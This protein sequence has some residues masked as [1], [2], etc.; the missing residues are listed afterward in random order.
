M[1][2]NPQNVK[3]AKDLLTALRNCS[4]RAELARA[5]GVNPRTVF[6]WQSKAAKMISESE[7]EAPVL[8]SEELEPEELIERICSDFERRHKAHK[9]RDWMEFKIDTEDPICIV[10]VGDPHVDDNGCNWPLLK[11]H[12]EIIAETAGMYSVPLGDFTNNWIG[13]LSSKVYPNQSTTVKQAWALAEWLIDKIN[14]LI[15]VGGNHDMWSKDKIGIDPLDWLAGN[16][17]KLDWQ[18]KFQLKFKNDTVVKIWAAHDFK[19]NSM[20]N[21]LHGPMKKEQLSGSVADIYAAGDKHNWII[22]NY[23]NA[24]TGKCP[25]MLRARG[26]KFI[27]HYAEQLGFDPQQ[28]GASIA[29]VI[30]PKAEIVNQVMAFPS[31]EKARDY[32][33][34]LRKKD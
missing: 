23:E 11:K 30:D 12:A 24:T 3:E 25:L 1:I 26:Y 7:V 8:S 6:R 13:R 10:F 15:M 14:P 9:E 34:F 20:W 5:N 29:V 32:L 31:V 2:K 27:D 17:I 16:R 18:A 21:P 22:T 4:S 28:N 19:G 33:Q